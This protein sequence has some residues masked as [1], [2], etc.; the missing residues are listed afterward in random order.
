MG[1]IFRKSCITYEKDKNLKGQAVGL[2]EG[3]AKFF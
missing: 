3:L 1:R 2:R